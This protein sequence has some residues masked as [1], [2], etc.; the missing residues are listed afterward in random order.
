MPQS[1]PFSVTYQW[2]TV[3]TQLRSAIMVFIWL[4]MRD[5]IKG[6][7]AIAPQFREEGSKDILHYIDIHMRL[8]AIIAAL[9]AMATSTPVEN[10]CVSFSVS[11]GTGCAWMCNY[12]SGALGTNNYYFTDNVCTYQTGG[13]VGNPIAGKTYTCCA[14]GTEVIKTE[15]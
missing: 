3:T 13:C 6:H 14:A 4:C 1:F 7:N 2:Y 10:G 12:C 11:G 5:S 15:L 9:F 8:F